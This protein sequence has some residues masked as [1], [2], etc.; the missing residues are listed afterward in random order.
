MSSTAIAAAARSDQI[1][2]LVKEWLQSGQDALPH[3]LI[4]LLHASV[5]T[6][7]FDPTDLRL[8]ERYKD[9][10]LSLHFHITDA[11]YDGLGKRAISEFC[12]VCHC[13]VA[14][15]TNDEIVSSA[16]I[17]NGVFGVARNDG[18]SSV[19]INVMEFIQD[20]QPSIFVR[21]S[22]RLQTLDECRGFY[23]NA[24]KSVLF[25]FKDEILRRRTY[26]ELIPLR[27][28]PVISDSELPNE[29]VERGTD[30]VEEISNNH[31]EFGRGIG[32][33][34][35]QRRPI[36]INV[37]L[38]NNVILFGYETSDDCERSVKMFLCPDEFELR[39]V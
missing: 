4:N 32:E 11:T 36:R 10:S 5:D 7:R 14:I 1:G 16:P 33:F 24:A 35:V 29:M 15:R 12:A 34:G 19:L 39:A 28:S 3:E 6:E 37:L 30:V 27:G 26:R 25:K 2:S 22:V 38:S 20:Q 18:Q 13:L 31:G 9:G 8:A 21:S 17:D 23:G